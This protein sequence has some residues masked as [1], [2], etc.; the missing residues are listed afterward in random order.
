MHCNNPECPFISKYQ[1]TSVAL[2]VDNSSE[3]HS[4]PQG[5]DSVNNA[6][7]RPPTK[8]REA[9]SSTG[10]NIPLLHLPHAYKVVDFSCVQKLPC[11][12]IDGQGG[13][14]NLFACKRTHGVNLPLGIVWI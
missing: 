13:V 2:V 4:T 5:K 14:Y 7:N 12:Y 8:L 10:K 11:T 1:S 6:D 9:L 3:V